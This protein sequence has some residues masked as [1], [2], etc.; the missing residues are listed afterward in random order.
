MLSPELGI[1]TCQSEQ[2][3]SSNPW[4]ALLVSLQ[5]G[6]EIWIAGQLMG[7]TSTLRIN[8]VPNSSN[9]VDKIGCFIQDCYY[10]T[11]RLIGYDISLGS[12]DILP[13]LLGLFWPFFELRQKKERRKHNL[14]LLEL[15][16][17]PQLIMS[18]E[19]GLEPGTLRRILSL[20]Y[21]CVCIITR[22]WFIWIQW[23]GGYHA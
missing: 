13:C 10:Y 21:I 2:L 16:A 14:P 1:L 15:S 23:Y 8:S 19:P 4:S 20:I 22:H 6:R 18:P 3:D 12:F 5:K 9:S 11:L 17:S 7:F